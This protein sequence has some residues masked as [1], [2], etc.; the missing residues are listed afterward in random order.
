MIG[1]QVFHGSTARVAGT[2]SPA[3]SYAPATGADLLFQTQILPQVS[4]T[5]A[6]TIPE[7]PEPLRLAVA[8]AYLLCRIADTIE[9]EVSLS[10]GQKQAAHE[11]LIAVVAGRAAP[12][13]FAD[14]MRALLS[15]GT[16]PAERALVEH[17]ACIVRITGSLHPRQRAA[18][19]RCVTVMC[20]GMPKFQRQKSLAGLEL[21]QDME[22]Y[23]YVVA[24]VVGEMLTELFSDYSP[25]I[26]SRQ[27][28]LMRR[29]VMFGQ[30]LQM[31]NIL[32]DRWEDRARGS[33]WLPREVFDDAGFALADAAPGDSSGAFA[34]GIERLIGIAH[35]Q[36]RSALDYT[37][38]IPAGE[39]G[40]RRFC[41]WS[42]GLAVLTLRRIHRNP[43][44]ASASEVKVTRRSVKAVVLLTRL[45]ARND[46]A[47]RGLFAVAAKGL[48]LEQETRNLFSAVSH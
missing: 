30:A 24:G 28:R 25:A 7:L 37:L 23:C 14:R 42:I 27:D 32:K 35:A 18:L 13:D 29:A 48:P 9:D 10:S 36:L 34:T 43:G 33:C 40:I 4:R 3:E 20:R 31:T 15:E 5:F 16:L 44:Y 17:A 22:R 1:Q 41:L 12:Q 26:A 11:T 47:L 8:N 38:L 21:L 6:L 2:A 19:R 46:T 45:A 39:R